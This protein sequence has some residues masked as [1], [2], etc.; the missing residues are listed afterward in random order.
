[1]SDM[2]IHYKIYNNV[3]FTMYVLISSYKGKPAPPQQV[4]HNVSANT[5]S[6]AVIQWQSP[7]YTGGRLIRYTVT[8]NGQTESVSGDVFTYTITGLDVN[9]DSIVEVTAV[10]SCGLE[11]EPA[12][13]TVIIQASLRGK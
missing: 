2:C 13:V 7:L 5:E 10:N 8:A 6:S 12:T 9:T 4:R 1:M 11:S 3:Q